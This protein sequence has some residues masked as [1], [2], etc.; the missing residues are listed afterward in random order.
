MNKRAIPGGLI[1]YDYFPSNAPSSAGK[2][3]SIAGPYG[4]DLAFTYDGSLTTSTSWSGDV[5]GS[6]AWQYNND[7][8]KILETVS[9]KKTKSELLGFGEDEFAPWVVGATM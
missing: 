6:V 5:T 1:D 2:V 4:V 8:Q 7:F 9:G 3:S